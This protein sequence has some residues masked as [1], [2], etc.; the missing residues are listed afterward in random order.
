M[1]NKS[2]RSSMILLLVIL[3]LLTVVAAQSRPPAR[4]PDISSIVSKITH[5]G[6]G[7]SLD[8][9]KTGPSPQYG[10]GWN[11]VHATNCLMLTISGND[12][13]VVYPEEGGYFYTTNTDY[14]N[15]IEPA[16]QLNHWLAFYVIDSNLD[17]NEVY[18]YTFQ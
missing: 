10:L 17:W 6:N 11:Y 9:A 7:A 3:G 14:Q 2:I 4:V 13:L 12:Y 1:F 16:C 18:T 15:V 8:T 5:P